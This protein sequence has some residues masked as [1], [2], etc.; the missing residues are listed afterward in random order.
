MPA[1][2][3]EDIPIAE[4]MEGYAGRFE[5]WGSLTA[6]FEKLPGGLDLAPL[7]EGLP[8]DKCQC[9]H[10]GFLERGRIRVRYA[11]HDETIEAGQAYYMAPGH[12]P[13]FEL[14]SET[15]E[16]SPTEELGKT[17][18]AIRRNLDR[19]AAGA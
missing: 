3:R 9:P 13:V 18:E 15:L 8:D 5:R 12:A 4:A 17:F 10:W 2:R 19:T 7:L 16:F 11:D 1:A 14:D 6:A